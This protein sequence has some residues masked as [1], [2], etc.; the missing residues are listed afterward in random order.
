MC[1]FPKLYAAF[2]I[3][4]INGLAISIQSFTT[5]SFILFARLEITTEMP[6]TF[7]AC[8]FKGAG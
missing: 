5:G 7:A 4:P 2:K 1:A 8:L 6:V 3:K